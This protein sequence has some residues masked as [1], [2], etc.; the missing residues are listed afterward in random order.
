MAR[1]AREELETKT[2][3]NVVSP[4]SAKRFFEAQQPKLN[5]PEGENEAEYVFMSG[6]LPPHGNVPVRYDVAHALLITAG[7]GDS[8]ASAMIDIGEYKDGSFYTGTNCTTA[9]RITFFIDWKDNGDKE[10]VDFLKQS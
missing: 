10:A 5:L 7:Q 6:Y 1:V 9:D 4:L 2:G 8:S 3:R